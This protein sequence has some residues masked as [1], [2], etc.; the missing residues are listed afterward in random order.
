M[1]TE[2]S[3]SLETPHQALFIL[4]SEGYNNSFRSIIFSTQAGVI[5]QRSNHFL[6]TKGNPKCSSSHRTLQNEPLFSGPLCSRTAQQTCRITPSL[7]TSWAGQ[8]LIQ[9]SVFS[10]ARRLCSLSST[11]HRG[12]H[13]QRP[14]QAVGALIPATFPDARLITLASCYSAHQQH[15]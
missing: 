3:K 14:T 5:L 11:L 7:L 1:V 4:A 2:S 10:F 8:L 15:F 6:S 12:S 13:S 9:T